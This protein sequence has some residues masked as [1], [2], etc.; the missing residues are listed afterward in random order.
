MR[1]NKIYEDIPGEET[2]SRIEEFTFLFSEFS[3][4]YFTKE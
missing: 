2:I 4:Q 1:A 3:R